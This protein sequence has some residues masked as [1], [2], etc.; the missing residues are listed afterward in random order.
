MFITLE[1]AEGS[2]KST[3]AALLAS[4]LREKQFAV[5]ETRE[6]GGTPT[7]NQLRQ[8]LLDGSESLSPVTEALLMTAARAEHVRSV[9][10]PALNRGAVV[11]CDRYVDSTLAYQGA[12]RGLNVKD[13]QWLQEFAIDGTWPDLTILLDIEAETGLQR[14]HQSGDSNRIDR[15]SLQ[16]H[17]RVVAWYRDRARHEPARWRVVDASQ[18]VETVRSCILAIVEDVLMASSPVPNVKG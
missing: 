4:S 17:Q 9:V 13:L 7:G 6:P 8:I 10:Q 5:V 1:G 12:G 11:I 14:R 3:Q 2:G 18:S 16:F 15:E